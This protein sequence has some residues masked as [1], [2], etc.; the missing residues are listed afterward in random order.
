[1]KHLLLLTIAAAGLFAADATGKWIG[2][3]T[4]SDDTTP[5]PAHIVLKQDG[6]TLTGT[7]GPDEGEQHA[8]QNG[9]V[10]D[11]TLTFEIAQGE[12]VMRFALKQDGDAIT[13][14]M[15]RQRGERTQTAK[16][17]LKRQR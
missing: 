12:G 13:G 11:G 6:S 10:E 5:R 8:I 14:E 15:T 17:E 7:A 16:M 2:T 9:K 4:P 1:M 3:F